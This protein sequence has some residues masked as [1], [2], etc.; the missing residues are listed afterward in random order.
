LCE[1]GTPADDLVAGEPIRDVLGIAKQ[2]QSLYE[3]L[4]EYGYTIGSGDN[5]RAIGWDWRRAIDDSSVQDLLEGTIVLLSQRNGGAKVVPIVHSTGGLVFRALLETRPRVA[6]LLDQVLAFG[7]PWAGTLAA[8]RYLAKGERFGF[9][10]IGLKPSEVRTVMR[11]AQAAYDLFPPDPL[12]TQMSS[13]S[14]KN[15]D[16][17]VRANG[18]QCGPLVELGWAGA[19]PDPLVAAGAAAADFRLGR[20]PSTLRLNGQAPPA[21]TNVVGWGGTTDVRCVLGA[22][23]RLAFQSGKDG[24]STVAAVSAAWLRGATVRTY[25]LPI[26]VYPTNGVPRPHSRLWDSPPV[27]EVFD[28]VLKDKAPEPFVCGAADGDEAIQRQIP[29]TLRFTAADERGAPLANATVQLK[30]VSGSSKKS[31]GGNVRME[32]VLK[33]T[34]LNPNVSGTD[35]FHFTALIEW[36]GG[37][38]ELP[39]LIRV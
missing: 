39:I 38:R 33:R 15:L 36:T 30:G 7:V 1:V 26:G 11:H 25:F 6:N 27:Y 9:G 18:A 29:C 10:P 14:G 21:I 20:R 5:F 13:A 34:N 23:G 31:F 19:P 12:K 32:L 16:L 28:Q 3:R 37:A 35:F 2:A 8:V 24:D 17:F 4:Q 22:D